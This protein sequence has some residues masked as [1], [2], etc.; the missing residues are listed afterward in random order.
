MKYIKFFNELTIKDVP[1]VGGKNASLGEMVQKLGKKINVPDGFAVT[2]QGYEYFL[3]KAGINEEIKRQLLGLDTSN[4][5]ELSERGQHSKRCAFGSY[6][7]GF[8]TGNYCSVPKTFQK[9]YEIPPLVRQ[10]RTRSG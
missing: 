7:F 8:K 9:I 4:M 2:A 3:E 10:R 1:L 6:S 5:K